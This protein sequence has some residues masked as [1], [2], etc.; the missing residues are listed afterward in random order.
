MAASLPVADGGAAASSMAQLAA[1]RPRPPGLAPTRSNSWERTICASPPPT[2]HP[3]AP[4]PL[5]LHVRALPLAPQPP[6]RPPGLPSLQQQVRSRL[7]AWR[8][9]GAPSYIMRWLREGVRCEWTTSPPPPF[10]HGVTPFT[11]EERSWV[12]KESDRCLLTGAWSP[13]TQLDYVSR[14][15]IVEHNG[16]RR[17]VLNFKYLNTFEQKRSCKFEPFTRLRRELL[18]DDW[19]FS[20]DLADAYH[21]IGIY[22]PDQKFFTFGLETEAGIQY[23]CASALSFGWTRSPWY[24]TQVCK[25]PVAF[26]RNQGAT[27]PAM[28]QRLQSTMPALQIR[29]LPWLDDF[30]FFMQGNH[31]QALAGR[32]NCF[33]VFEDLGLS[34]SPTKGQ[35][36]PSYR[37]KDHLGFSIDSHVGEFGVT[38]RRARKL[39]AGA[40][41]LLRHAADHARMVRA[42]ELAAFA[43]LAQSTHLAIALVR[44]WLR[45]PY[46]DLATKCRWSG[47]VRLSRQ[48][49]ADVRQF[50]SIPSRHRRRPIW[51]RP[52]TAVGHVD[53]GPRGWGGQLDSAAAVPPAAG[54]WTAAQ[55]ALHI[56][57]RELIAVRLW[58]LWFLERVRSRRVLLFEDNQAVVA[59]LTSLTTRSPELMAELRELLEILDINDIALRALYIRS[60]ENIVAD[61]YSRLARP[62]D[63]TLL[64]S[65]FDL[66]QTWWGACHVDAF[67][68]GATALLP[69]WWAALPTAGC[70]AVDAFA[71]PWVGQR[72]WAHPPPSLLPQLVQ[73]LAAEPRAEALVAAPLWP[74]EA[75][76]SS[77]MHLSSEHATFPAGSLCRV[78]FDAPTRL[79]TWALT[80]FYVP[81][82]V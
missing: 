71:Q 46:N 54:F 66:V 27:Q 56:T 37:L 24:F 30:A 13:A 62:R 49:L 63:Y 69:R 5:R 33:Q 53:A 48:S 6:T 4:P 75:W 78:A 70:E 38:V 34:R 72:V 16:K 21:H 40:L 35:W 10:H 50:V 80:V 28:G 23:F 22:E 29:V 59:I 14:A 76:Y 41:S 65:I 74:G 79:E 57:H 8:R 81:C 82:R 68:S 51:L 15:F 26:I 43:G 47:W 52:D 58:I 64:Q 32:D 67:A 1:T 61:H 31:Q 77:L 36:E 19:M 55:A 60:A 9:M 3:H 39:R 11:S 12:S 42:R 17:L 45:A 73:L 18:Q 44:C 2:P 7:G 20:C 25:V